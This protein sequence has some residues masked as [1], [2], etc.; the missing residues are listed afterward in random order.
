MKL[1]YS[2]SQLEMLLCGSGRNRTYSAIKQQIY[3]LSRLSN[4]G[5]DPIVP[6]TLFYNY[7]RE[8]SNQYRITELVWHL[9]LVRLCYNPFIYEKRSQLFLHFTC[10]VILEKLRLDVSS[11]LKTIPLVVTLPPL[12]RFIINPHLSLDRVLVHDTPNHVSSIL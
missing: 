4:C 5:A 2:T 7:T 12:T 1:F 8:S 11:P 10:F 6:T 9:Y 3:S